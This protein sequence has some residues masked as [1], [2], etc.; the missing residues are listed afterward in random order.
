MPEAKDP[1][2]WLQI[3]IGAL[4]AM[5]SAW[6]ASYLGVAGTVIGA[7]VGSVTASVATAVY[8]HGLDRGSALITERVSEAP[9]ETEIEISQAEKQPI[10]WKRVAAWSALA[11]AVA[12]AAIG[13][14]ELVTDSPFGN[15]DNPTISRPWSNPQT[16]PTE[17][18]PTPTV[19]ATT[20]PTTEPTTQPT[21]VATTAPTTTPTTTPTPPAITE[22][23]PEAAAPV[24]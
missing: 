10:A 5:T 2:P 15:K 9:G 22:P 1:K 7:A 23:T 24:E 14:Y 11:L 18:E 12:L 4:A 19:Q 13:G 3:L 16:E 21:T 8:L 17:A 20:A 6:V